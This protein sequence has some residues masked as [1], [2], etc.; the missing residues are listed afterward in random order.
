MLYSCLEELRRLSEIFV[1]VVFVTGFQGTLINTVVYLVSLFAL[2][3][4]G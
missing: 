2:M 4:L 1:T 3:Y